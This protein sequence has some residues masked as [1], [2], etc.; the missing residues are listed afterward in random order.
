M[1]V[2]VLLCASLCNKKKLTQRDTEDSQRDTE[3]HTLNLKKN[4]IC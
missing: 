1:K 4:Y 2:S 3:V